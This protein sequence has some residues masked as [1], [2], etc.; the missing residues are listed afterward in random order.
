M[1]AESEAKSRRG[2]AHWPAAPQ[3]FTEL[4]LPNRLL[5]PLTVKPGTE[6]KP[7]PPNTKV[8]RGEA[9]AETPAESS[10]IPIAPTAGTIGEIR[11]IRLTNGQPVTAVEFVP[12]GEAQE[13]ASPANDGN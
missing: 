7:K 4:P 11:P 8:R 5:I 3:E 1:P 2:P 13:M 12:T 9:V 6:A 10:H